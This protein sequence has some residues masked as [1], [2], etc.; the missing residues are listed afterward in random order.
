[1]DEIDINM[2]TILQ[3]DGR[4]AI[5]E[6]S[7]QLALSRPSVTE[8]LNRLQEQGIIKGFKAIVPPASV[9]RTLLVMIELDELK[10]TPN[11][12][13]SIL[14]QEPRVI[15]CH[16]ATGHVH[17]YVKAALRDI[18]DLQELIERLIPYCNTRTSILL[19]ESIEE[20]LILPIQE[21]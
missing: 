1:M 16:R 4:I 19:G 5:S 20:K 3:K 10:V 2:L 6:L 21:N 14:S 7:K 11:E 13:E 8:R 12:I 18:E 15:E 17:F 9:G